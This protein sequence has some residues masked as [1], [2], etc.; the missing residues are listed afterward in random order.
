MPS[1]YEYNA[2]EY[3]STVGDMPRIF[4]YNA[5]EYGSTAGDMPRHFL[6]ANV[7][8]CIKAAANECKTNEIHEVIPFNERLVTDIICA[9]MVSYFFI[10]AKLLLISK[11]INMFTFI[12]LLETIYVFVC[13]SLKY[14]YK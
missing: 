7:N 13:I 6:T 5:G 1:I 2:G 9:I 3:G 4:D 12:S 11:Y 10:S 14:T 8:L